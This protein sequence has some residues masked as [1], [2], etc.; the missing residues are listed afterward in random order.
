[1]KTKFLYYLIISCLS[2]A[3]LFSCSE[4][5]KN[6]KAHE[7]IE[8]G[9]LIETIARVIRDSGLEFPQ[10]DLSA[11][12]GE[13]KLSDDLLA[14]ASDY[15]SVDMGD[16]ETMNARIWLTED[17][18]IIPTPEWRNENP[19]F[20]SDQGLQMHTAQK[21][22]VFTIYNIPQ[23]DIRTVKLN[24][25]D[26]ETGIIEHSFMTENYEADPD[27]LYMAMTEVWAEMWDV[28]DIKSAVGPCKGG[29]PLT[30]K[31]NST[32]TNETPE[33]N[34]YEKIE[35]TITLHFDESKGAYTGI[36]EFVWIEG[37]LWSEETGNIPF[38]SI[39]GGELE[40]VKLITP[41]MGRNSIDD[42]TMTFRAP[43]INATSQ[44]MLFASFMAFY[45]MISGDED[46]FEYKFDNWE[47]SNN[48]EIIMAAYINNQ[49]A[50]DDVVL[51]ETTTIEITR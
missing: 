18:H 49:L 19:N 46:T 6:E 12:R 11:D 45:N 16:G 7:N 29:D 26:I 44:S 22:F 35:V 50:D 27:W 14:L 17:N 47:L 43:R 36:G 23:S 2:A 21:L 10:A 15:M 42:A 25:I 37:W 20:C 32:V 39:K 51:T 34:S 33:A 24:Y 13:A 41:G 5:D 4:E 30:L 9:Y 1:M 3:F 40:I 38:P 48:P 8:E 28:V 31:F